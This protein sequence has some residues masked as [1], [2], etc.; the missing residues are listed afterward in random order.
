MHSFYPTADLSVKTT[1]DE[2][3]SFWGFFEISLLHKRPATL[4]V[5]GFG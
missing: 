3:L 5:T 2:Q 4:M 1:S